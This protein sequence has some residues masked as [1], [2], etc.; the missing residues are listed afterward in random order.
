MHNDIFIGPGLEV[1]QYFID[2]AEDTAG[3]GKAKGKYE[4]R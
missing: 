3:K 2:R 4:K 1:D